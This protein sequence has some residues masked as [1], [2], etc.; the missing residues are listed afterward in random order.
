MHKLTWDDVF[1]GGD[2]VAFIK[3]KKLSSVVTLWELFQISVDST[4]QLVH[5]F[6]HILQ[7]TKNRYINIIEHLT[8]QIFS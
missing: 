1:V 2:G 6:T 4:F 8:I 7:V 3:H 5:L